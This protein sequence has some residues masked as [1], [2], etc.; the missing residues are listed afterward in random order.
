MILSY[1]KLTKIN[2]PPPQIARTLSFKVKI[3]LHQAPAWKLLMVFCCPKSW[4]AICNL[5]PSLCL[6]LSLLTVSSL[7]KWKHQKLLGSCSK[8]PYFLSH[9]IICTSETT[10]SKYHPDSVG[11]RHSQTL[12][13]SSYLCT[14]SFSLHPAALCLLYLLGWNSYRRGWCPVRHYTFRSHHIW[15]LTSSQ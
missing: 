7:S 13:P 6:Q 12:N 11:K 15:E 2:K 4:K 5:D 14:Y 9:W 8:R 10:I 1:I 3:R